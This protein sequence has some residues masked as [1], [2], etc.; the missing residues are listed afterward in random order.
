MS[1]LAQF[2]GLYFPDL[3]PNCYDSFNKMK[4]D[5]NIC[6]MVKFSATDQGL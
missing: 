6:T 5:L 4:L 1:K 3:N 2:T